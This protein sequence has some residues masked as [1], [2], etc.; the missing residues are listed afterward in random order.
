MVSSRY[1]AVWGAR[2]ARGFPATGPP[3]PLGGPKQ[4][5]LLAMLLLH[6][7]ELVSRDQLINALWGERPP[8]ERRRVTGRLRLPAAQAG[9]ARSPA[10]PARRLSP[11]GRAR[12]SSTPISSTDWSR[13]PV[14]PPAPGTTPP[15]STP[16]TRPW[17]CGAGRHG[18]TCSTSRRLRGEA[19]RL[20]ESRLSALESRIEA[21]I[22]IGG[23]A[24]LVPEL[25]QLVQRASTTG[26]AAR[27][28]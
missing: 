2:A 6:A 9:R 26:A 28:V 22:A 15:P 1:D 24:E 13:P 7:N 18:P 27:A 8:A 25:E 23:G 21:E 16:W 11:G 19:R 14:A 12:A 4:R 20:E 5:T 3:V 10:A 17:G